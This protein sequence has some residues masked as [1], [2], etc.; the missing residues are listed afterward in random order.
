MG[1]SPAPPETTT[2]NGAET[3]QQPPT[4]TDISC[5]GSDSKDVAELRRA[6]ESGPLFRA[7]SGSA[8]ATSCTVTTD[9]ESVTLEYRFRDGG[10]FRAT[11]DPSIEYT[12]LIA[13]FASPPAESPIDIM[14]RVERAAFSPDGCGIDWKASAEQRPGDDPGATERVYRGDTCNCQA[15]VRADTAT[16]VVG[17]TFRSAC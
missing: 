12:E 16:R 1:C 17:L 4:S 14:R 13:R 5:N 11:R 15:I 3:E 10:S 7:V 8:A 9:A 2:R 6:T